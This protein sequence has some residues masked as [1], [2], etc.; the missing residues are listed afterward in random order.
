MWKVLSQGMQYAHVQYESPMNSGLKVMATV[1]VNDD[2][3][4][5]DTDADVRAMTRKG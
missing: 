1:K 4:E 3:A 5:A 2:A